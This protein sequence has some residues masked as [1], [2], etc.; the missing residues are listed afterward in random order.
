MTKAEAFRI[1]YNE[2]VK[3]NMFTGNYD[4]KHGNFAFM[5]GINTVMEVIADE[6]GCLEKFEEMFNHNMV[7]SERKVRC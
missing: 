3:Q 2:L 6:A 4:A 1:V 5:C 7:E